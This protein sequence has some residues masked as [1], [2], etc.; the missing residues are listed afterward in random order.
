MKV[1]RIQSIKHP[2]LD[3]IGSALNP[4]RWNTSNVRAI[5]TSSSPSLAQLEILVNTDDWRFFATVHHQIITSEIDDDAIVHLNEKDLPKGWASKKVKPISQEFGKRYLTD[6]NVLA[7]SVPSVV[8]PLERNIIIN[9]I[10]KFF[11]SIIEID[12]VDFNI[13]G[14]L[15]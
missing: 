11:S 14:R 13:D 10:S 2:N 8:T 4:G 9:P 15:L 7:F 5:Y 6:I 12:R 3:G 1:Y